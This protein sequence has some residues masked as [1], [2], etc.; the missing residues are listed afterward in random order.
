MFGSSSTTSS[1]ASGLVS[2]EVPWDWLPDTEPPVARAD[3]VVMRT[4]VG[5]GA[6]LPLDATWELPGSRSTRGR[7]RAAAAPVADGVVLRAA[8]S[9]PRPQVG[10]YGAHRGGL[11]RDPGE[12]VRR[13]V[14]RQRPDGVGE[15]AA[16]TRR[17]A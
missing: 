12:E 1:R 5:A 4:T 6:A 10:T 3:A 11:R 2:W 8:Q 16:L 15:K 7:H 14:G 9:P 13:G 17:H